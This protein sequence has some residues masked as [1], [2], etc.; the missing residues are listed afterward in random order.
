MA[1]R[2][3]SMGRPARTWRKGCEP[4][5]MLLRI[6]RRARPRRALFSRERRAR[7]T[8]RLLH[9]LSNPR[10]FLC[11]ARISKTCSRRTV[12]DA[13][14]R[15]SARPRCAE[16]NLHLPTKRKKPGKEIASRQNYSRVSESNH[17]RRRGRPQA[18]PHLASPQE[19]AGAL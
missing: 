13:T 4:S 16:S 19:K 14:T 1:S 7:C 8:I 5:Q 3:S 2:C 15:P 17:E 11:Q 18:S 12:L 6:R 9:N 10:R